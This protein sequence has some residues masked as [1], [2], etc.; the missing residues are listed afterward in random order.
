[1]KSHIQ[2]HLYEIVNTL[3]NVENKFKIVGGEGRFSAWRE[4]F[5]G[6]EKIDKGEI[7]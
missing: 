6:G 1:M 2:F 5:Q 7:P 4:N 3:G